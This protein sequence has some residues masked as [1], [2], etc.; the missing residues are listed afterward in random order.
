MLSVG[1][2]DFW[3]RGT[4]VKK[5]KPKKKKSFSPFLFTLHTLHLITYHFG[6]GKTDSGD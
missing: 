2:F 6:C 1:L 5:K 3:A 4:A